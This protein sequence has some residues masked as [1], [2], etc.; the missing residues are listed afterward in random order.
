MS[1]GVVLRNLVAD[2]AAA[3]FKTRRVTPAEIPTVIDQIAS[4]L[5]AASAPVAENQAETAA[6]P[7]LSADQ[8]RKSITPDALISFEDNRPYK[9][10]WR[11]L[12]GKGLSPEEYRRKWGLP[13]SYPMAAASY[14][15]ARA[16]IGKVPVIAAPTASDAAPLTPAVDFAAP[17]LEPVPAP[18]E[19][20]SAA[21]SPAAAIKQ[22]LPGLKVARKS[23]PLPVAFR[24]RDTGRDP[25][26]DIRHKRWLAML[27][28][29]DWV[30]IR[31]IA[32][33][34]NHAHVPP[35]LT[36]LSAPL[37]V[38]ACLVGHE[39]RFPGEHVGTLRS[40]QVA[41]LISDRGE[42]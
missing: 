32:R 7:K 28:E 34:V 16:S 31:A 6:Q 36:D 5:A 3:Y 14:S 37:R 11:H 15:E 17:E 22:A 12:A 38:R 40:G 1:E 20:P 24:P 35:A 30:R 8:I 19:P 27:S 26:T 21:V 23:V 10:L 9:T 39:A 29:A 25:E 2:A 4:R 41:V 33:Q 42:H 18:A 13:E